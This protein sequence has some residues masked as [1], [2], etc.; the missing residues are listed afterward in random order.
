MFDH[1]QKRK[2]D[3]LNKKDKSIKGSIDNDI[4]RLVNEINSKKDFYTTSSCAGRIVLLELKSRKKTNCS[5]IF[6]KHDKVNF[7]EIIGSLEANLS[8]GV[9]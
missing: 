1:F 2:S 9:A 8:T 5:W 7:K 4:S 6:T 3:F